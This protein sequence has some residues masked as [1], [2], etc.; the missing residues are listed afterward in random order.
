MSG[1]PDLI[2]R[3]ARILGAAGEAVA[4]RG[5]RILA[6]GG[7]SALLR[8]R[9][10]ATRVVEVA[11]GLICAGFHDAHAHLVATGLARRELDLHGRSAPQIVDAVR[12]R[13]GDKRAGRWIVGS[14]FDPTLFPGAGG[15]ARERLDAVT[16]HPIL[17]R[18][19]DHHAVALNSAALARVGFLPTP[20]TIAGGV[21]ETDGN[22]A[23]T[24]IAREAS[25]HAAEA[26]A[27]DLT[28]AER[29]TATEA[30]LP[31]LWAA[32]IT[33]V[34][35]MSGS[36]WLRD[37]RAL[38][39]ARR[40]GVTVFASVAPGDVGDSDMRRPGRRLHVGAMK[41]FLDGAL[42]TRTAL[43]LEPYEGDPAHRGI[44]V[45]PATL[46]REYVQAAADAGLAA[47]LHAIGDAAVRT[48]LDAIEASG[49][50]R[51]VL[52]HRVEHAQ[53]VHDDDLPRFAAL[54]VTASV[55]P[56]HMA[57]DAALVHRHWGPRAREAFPLRRLLDSGAPLAFG[58]DM[59]IET[60]DVLDGVRC[61]VGRTGRDG[62][63]LHP[64]EALTTQEALLAYTQGAAR[65]VGAEREIGV[66]APGLRADITILSADVVSRP[67]A[68][69]EAVVAATVIDGNVVFEGS[70][71]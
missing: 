48:A 53:M 64:E 35:D 8:E 68:L 20:P 15:S 30:L 39:D 34:H 2:V 33:A 45:V 67:D 9:G 7:A 60:F 36:R 49:G 71:A 19:H 1:V 22:G 59:P 50:S 17:L 70:A 44:E 5:G 63:P 57:E 6:V 24:G 16:T 62:T 18:S 23:P 54:G 55:Q 32:G 52:R 38:D 43:L 29:T 25:A 61:A 11:G 14:G 58:S 46:L 21:V 47:W 31:E 51:G 26:H 56:V 69:S 37:L 41:A 40:L 28:E 65:A 66:L 12:E 4:V 13:A 42:G 27:D 10:P 3:G